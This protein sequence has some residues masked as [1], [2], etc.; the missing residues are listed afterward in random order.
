MVLI[1]TLNEDLYR[2]EI[3][4]Q[5]STVNE[6]LETLNVKISKWKQEIAEDFWELYKRRNDS[7]ITDMFAG[8]VHT[9]LKC[10]KCLK[11]ISLFDPMM[12]LS[13]N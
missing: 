1:D 7:V 3:P 4:K 13:V 10:P 9:E 2:G 5:N 6:K 11:C 12:S 8:L